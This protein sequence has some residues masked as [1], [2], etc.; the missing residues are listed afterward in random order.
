MAGPADFDCSG[1]GD[2]F[3]TKAMCDD[4]KIKGKPIDHSI[5]V[6][7]YGTDKHKGNYWLIKK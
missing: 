5:T 2:C 3:I 7:G 1:T 4:P 6:V